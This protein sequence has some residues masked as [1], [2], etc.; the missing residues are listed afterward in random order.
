MTGGQAGESTA[1]KK[2]GV[3]DRECATKL[4]FSGNI[5]IPNVSF[6][7]AAHSDVNLPTF[8][9]GKQED[10]IIISSATSRS[11]VVMDASPGVHAWWWAVDSVSSQ[12]LRTILYAKDFLKHPHACLLYRQWEG[13]MFFR[14]FTW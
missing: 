1:E 7:L 9:P 12:F 13:V 6:N 2:R 5:L 10:L 14:N 3:G 4:Q 8:F 11:N